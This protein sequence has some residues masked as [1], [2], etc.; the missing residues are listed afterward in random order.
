MKFTRSTEHPIRLFFCL[1]NT[2]VFT[3]LLLF[4]FTATNTHVNAQNFVSLG[5]ASNTLT[6]NSVPFSGFSNTSYQRFSWSNILLKDSLLNGVNLPNGTWIDSIVFFKS[7][8]SAVLQ[9]FF[10]SMHMGLANPLGIPTN[11]LSAIQ[12]K[13]EV[14]RNPAFLIGA[15]QGPV[16][17][18]FRNPYPYWGGG[19]ALATFVDYGPN[20]LS[21]TGGFMPEWTA[22]SNLRDNFY[23]NTSNATPFDSLASG[24]L[25]SAVNNNMPAMRIYYRQRVNRDL[26][27]REIRTPSFIQLNTL[28]QIHVAVTNE[29]TDTL[30]QANLS[31]QQQQAAPVSQSFALNLPPDSSTVLS[32]SFPILAPLA[33]Q[34]PLRVWVNSLNNGLSDQQPSNDS[35][36]L[37]VN[38]A[39]NFDTLHV[40]QQYTFTDLQTLFN[41]LMAINS[42]QQL[43][44]I[45]HEN[46]V[47]NF[48]LSNYQLPNNQQLI[49]RGVHDSIVLQGNQFGSVLLLNNVKG[50]QLRGL[51]FRHNFNTTALN[52]L[53][54]VVNSSN[55]HIENNR[56]LGGTAVN[57]NHLIV[58]NN[59]REIVLQNNLFS[60]GNQ[61]FQLVANAPNVQVGRVSLLN[62]RFENQQG[63]GMQFS[64]GVSIDSLW[65][66]G[67]VLSN[68]QP[69][70]NTAV[71]IDISNVTRL[72]L[73]RNSITGQIGQYGIRIS[74]F[75]GD[76]LRPNRIINNLVSGLFVNDLCSGLK[77]QG[78]N[79]GGDSVQHHMEV[80]YNSIQVRRNAPVIQGASVIDLTTASTLSPV[81]SRF[82][83]R[84]NLVILSVPSTS[85][86]A[87]ILGNSHQTITH[88]RA[89]FSHN[90]YH[91]PS[92]FTFRF[93]AGMSISS[94]STLRSIYPNIELFSSEGD[95]Q[96][97]DAANHNLRFFSSAPMSKTALPIPG[98]TTD[99]DGNPRTNQPDKGAYLRQNL[100]NSTHLSELIAPTVTVL[101]HDTNYVL[102]VKFKNTGE[103]TISQL[104]F[105][106][107]FGFKDTV[108]E[109]WTGQLMPGDSMLFSF[110][111][112]LRIRSDSV[113]IPAFKVWNRQL[114]GNFTPTPSRDT[115]TALFCTPLSAGTYILRDSTTAGDAMDEWLRMLHCAGVRGN[116]VLK[117]NFRNNL[118]QNKPLGI[119]TIP[120]TSAS[121]PLIIDGDGDTL[122]I[123]NNTQ[124][125]PLTLSNTKHV[126]VKGFVF[127]VLTNLN[128]TAILRLSAT[129]SVTIKQNRFITRAGNSVRQA[130]YS[131]NFPINGA[132]GFSHALYIDSN[133]IEG[134]Y[135]SGIWIEG[136]SNSVHRGLKVTNN[137]IRCNDQGIS[138]SFV[139]SAEI[140][141]ND[142]G[143]RARNSSLHLFGVGIQASSQRVAVHSN[144]IYGL[145]STLLFTNTSGIYIRTPGLSPAIRN[146]VYNNLI[147]DLHAVRNVN[148]IYAVSSSS[149]L[150]ANNTIFLRDT[151]GALRSY[152]IFL[153]STI[154]QFQIINNN[155]SIQPLPNS[156]AS[157]LRFNQHF[158]LQIN[159]NNYHVD[160]VSS[161]HQ[162]IIANAVRYP[163][164]AAYRSAFPSFDQAG[165][166][167]DPLF[168]DLPNQNFV[169]QSPILYRRGLALPFVRTDFNRISRPNPPSLGAFEDTLL[170]PTGLKLSAFSAIR[171]NDGDTSRLRPVPL[172]VVLTGAD[173]VVHLI[174]RYRINQQNW[175]SDTLQ[176][177]AG[178]QVIQRT[179]GPGIV[180]RE[181]VDTLE[182]MAI[183]QYQGITLTDT[184]TKIVQSQFLTAVSVP[185]AN[186]FESPQ[187]VGDYQLLS[188]QYG[189]VVQIGPPLLS[190]PLQGL[191]SLVMSGTTTTPSFPVGI[192]LSNAFQTL[193]NHLSEMRILV[194]PG[195]EGKLRLSFRLKMTGA[196]NTT[197]FRV[198]VNNNAI[199]PAATAPGIGVNPVITGTP[200]PWLNISY[201]LDSINNGS[202]LI[203]SFQSLAQS[204]YTSSNSVV[205][206]SLRIYFEP[207]VDFTNLTVFQDTLC[208]PAP[209][210]VSVTATPFR[211]AISTIQLHFQTDT[212]TWASLPMTPGMSIGQYLGT[213]PPQPAINKVKYYVRAGTS[214][215]LFWTTDTLFFENLPYRLDLGP[216]R[217]I[218]SGQS[219]TLRPKIKEAGLKMLRITEF[220][221]F[222]FGDGANPNYP[223]GITS[224][225]EDILEIANYGTE[226]VLLDDAELL[227]QTHASNFPF[228]YRFP[229]GV[230]LL[231]L[232]RA[233]VAF[234]KGIDDTSAKL[235]FTSHPSTISLNFLKTNDGFVVLRQKATKRFIDGVI[236][237]DSIYP[238]SMF[239]PSNLWSGLLNPMSSTGI[240]R[241][242]LRHW[243][244]NAW[245]L[246]SSSS[247]HNLG[248]IDS[249]LQL[250]PMPQDIRWLN[251]GG[252]LLATG[253][254]LVVSPNAT[255]AYIAETNWSNCLKS[256]TILVQVTTNP[257]ADLSVASIISPETGDSVVLNAPLTPRVRIKN[258]SG[259]A[260]SNFTVQLLANDT[261][262]SS[263]NVP[264]GL[265]AFDSMVVNLPTWTP[266]MR[267]YNL[268]YKLVAVNDFDNTNHVLCRQNVRFVITIAVQEEE[269]AQLKL[270]PNPA[271]D[272]LYVQVGSRFSS[273]DAWKIVDASG[274]QVA[275]E[276]PPVEVNTGELEF[277]IAHLAAGVYYLQIQSAGKRYQNKFVV[278]RSH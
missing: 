47:G 152:G 22:D 80:Y 153:D 196:F 176:N 91:T 155:I 264:Q 186:D 99:I 106:Y 38:T 206:D 257:Q 50:V 251:L 161:P 254:S 275:L 43:T 234:G 6:N 40:G 57:R 28:T 85:V 151:V 272:K 20:V 230:M 92:Q 137:Y 104:Q 56:F 271:S 59:P 134:N 30:Y 46:Q 170:E 180:L 171:T 11:W 208:N 15:N 58:F 277:S 54:Q 249:S 123:S 245:S 128:Q 194:N 203:L 74:R 260:A 207:D 157:A 78:V 63:T 205:I 181:G 44:I 191:G 141:F 131:G 138:V 107:I 278:I 65:I 117:T 71:G 143:L 226:A 156:E 10:I 184:V 217:T 1:K 250:G 124:A 233:I 261:L 241:T 232:E 29:G 253:D 116:V 220:H 227:L 262:V 12:T 239:S 103:N 69:P 154:T 229:S 168:A 61:G 221:L 4:F 16:V 215:G 119:L 7:S 150:I 174:L 2:S 127:D 53:L 189:Q 225:H 114:I 190:T 23:F 17:F 130:I 244:A 82:I 199:T 84:N 274:R 5:N 273:G 210:N 160:A 175:I 209:R 19:I 267:S 87:G 178:R 24:I 144:K 79:Q 200:N 113:F 86:G 237:N 13:R 228:V 242:N 243:G 126:V 32:F 193:P 214:N 34:F 236:L 163:N 36:L 252:Q 182:A 219:A 3:C 255:Q 62:N 122:R 173:T 169:A 45:L 187:S 89:T 266:A 202:P 52:Y 222:R 88:P 14:L 177:V 109:D 223:V 224:A 240:K 159:Y 75:E 66:E 256:D 247:P 231:P 105:G 115:L 158:T 70:A 67:N 145:H 149:M 98:I 95:P 26:A 68:T 94:V 212:N 197:F 96:V 81:W 9:P 235:F 60:H 120:G 136:N 204:H 132:T 172:E 64:G 35:L 73:Q 110:N 42:P 238:A 111:Q 140:A 125:S 218:F 192:T 27:L 248:I 33:H 195:R 41:R 101:N 166:S 165:S 108:R 48:N 25:P 72:M 49:L 179:F 39:T 118:L 258:L 185:H 164:F 121:N 100:T 31:Y 146:Y 112:P 83:F 211:T 142:I 139:D 102:T 21:S 268:C 8:S 167:A 246:N 129:D 51:R 270:Y 201:L 135:I 18:K 77:I 269:L 188:A 97:F 90:H 276:E 213:I 216:D 55:V 148:G 147:Y 37:L 259:T 162:L 76:S 265:G 93:S 133:H 198:L 183:A 263:I